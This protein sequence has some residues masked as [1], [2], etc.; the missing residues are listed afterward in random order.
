MH[1]K[2]GRPRDTGQ[3]LVAHPDTF[4]LSCRKI[5]SNKFDT[6]FINQG[7]NRQNLEKGMRD[8]WIADEGYTFVQCDQS[9]ADALIVA[10]LCRAGK[11]R[12]LFQNGI[13]PHVYMSLKLFPDV[14]AKH[15]GM[16]KIAAALITPI[17]DLKKLSFW[18]ELVE[19]IKSSDNW[20][21]DQRYY[22]IAKKTVHSAS[23][24]MRGNTFRMSVLQESGGTIIITTKDAESFLMKFHSEFPEIHD[25]HNRLF[26]EAR[27]NKRIVNL[28]GFPYNITNFI[29]PNDFKDL[30]AW[31]P[32]STVA[33]INRQAYCDLQEYIEE[34]NRDWHLLADTH[35]SYMQQV[36]DCDTL[37]AAKKMKEFIEVE[38][39]APDGTKFRMKSE[40]QA[41]KNWG[42]KKASNP[43]GLEEVKL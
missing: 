11:Y 22:H 4:R 40:V 21:S 28:F 38:L 39:E 18:S 36:I 26:M 16:E 13:K 41:G 30:I 35:D 10:H 34:E 37:E 6:P 42:P 12:S 19:L 8:I 3:Y 15:I 20:P 43:Q 25:W 24:G 27:N 5:L 23:Y 14:W 33:C 31:I 2:F 9:G 1:K 29:N 32:Q 7:G 17:A